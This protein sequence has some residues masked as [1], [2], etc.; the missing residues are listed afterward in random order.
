MND[1]NL[2]ELR[3][4]DYPLHSYDKIRFR[5]TDSLGHVNNALFSTFLETGRVELL[6][7][8]EKPLVKKSVAFVIAGQRLDLLSEIMWPGT[9]DIGT[10]VRKIG[11]SSICLVQGLYQSGELAATA[12]TVIV[13]IDEET[14]SSKPLD[15]ESKELLRKLRM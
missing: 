1:L 11:N 4:E 14:R 13:Q 8:P 6:Y 9:I 15:E 5:D 10:G 3:L 2:K 7:N 12:E